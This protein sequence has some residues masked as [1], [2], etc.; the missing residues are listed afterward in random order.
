[1]TPGGEADRRRRA[2]RGGR[3]AEFL[4]SLALMAKGFSILERRFK[5]PAGEID[6][7]AKRG[8]LLVFAEVKARGTADQAVEAVTA[9]ARRRI[10]RAAGLFLSRRAHLADCVMRYDILAVSGLRVR[11]KPDAWREGE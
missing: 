10:E 11:H 9:P 4:A 5:T 1:M 8:P 3:R 6:L 7:I 2:E